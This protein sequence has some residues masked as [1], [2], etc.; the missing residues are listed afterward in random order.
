MSMEMVKSLMKEAGWGFLATTDGTRAAVRPMGGWAWVEK[1]L[2][3]A[4]GKESGK[5][6]HL[7]KVPH[8][9]FCFADSRGRHVRISG[10]CRVSHDAADKRTLYELVPALEN[11]TGGPED[12]NFVVIRIQVEKVRFMSSTDMKYVDVKTE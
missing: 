1:E 4:S 3:C 6:E 9:E 10:H 5:I 7:K 11:Y 12:P 2:W 8:A